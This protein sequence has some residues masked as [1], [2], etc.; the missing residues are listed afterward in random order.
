MN[1]VVSEWAEKVREKVEEV[2]EK[3]ITLEKS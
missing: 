3:L 1:G 2:G